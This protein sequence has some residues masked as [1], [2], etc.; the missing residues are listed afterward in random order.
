MIIT[1]KTNNYYGTVIVTA[2][3]RGT[4]I[5]KDFTIRAVDYTA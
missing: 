1:K 2:K 3:V 4:S 5:T